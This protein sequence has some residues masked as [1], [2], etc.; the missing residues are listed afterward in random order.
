MVHSNLRE[1]F[2][3]LKVYNGSAGSNE[4]TDNMTLDILHSYY[5]NFL[6]FLKGNGREHRW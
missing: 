2:E 4:K 1:C 6:D 3:P 5:K